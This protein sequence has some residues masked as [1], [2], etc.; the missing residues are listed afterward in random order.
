MKVIEL[1]NLSPQGL[2]LAERPDP[3]AG[4]GQI[5]V[6]MRAASLNYRDLLIIRGEYGPI[7]PPVI[8]VSDGVG[9]VVALGPGVRRFAVGD[10]VSPI[11]VTNWID[12]TLPVENMR[13]LGG[14]LDGALAEYMV[15]SEEAAVRAPAHLSDTEA[16][17]LPV[18]AVTAWHA[19]FVHGAVKPGQVVVVQGTGGVSLFALLLARAAG[20]EVVVTSGSQAKLARALELGAHHGI[21]YRETPEWH[22]RVLEITRGRG[23]DHVIDV[24]G[25]E[26]LARSIAA[27]GVEGTVYVVGMVRGHVASIPLLATMRRSVR[28][29]SVAVGHRASFE[30]LVRAM[31]L[32]RIRPVVDRT[33]AVSQLHDALAYLENGN[34]FGKVALSF[35]GFASFVAKDP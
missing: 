6:R 8:P 9:E 20:A 27:T 7:T 5:V 16:A 30:A 31:E 1:A 35:D 12:G 17:T 4:P 21:N 24:A 28:L 23:A 10:R 3:V 11:Y 29:Q 19:L 32:H 26:E 33:F 14:P 34:H 25:G 2:R 13:R 18:A 15:V 22:Q